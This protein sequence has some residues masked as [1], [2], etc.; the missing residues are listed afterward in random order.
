MRKILIPL[1]VL[2]AMVLA[3]CGTSQAASSCSKTFKVGFVTD[4]GKLGDK[5]FNDAGWKGVQDAAADSSLC[6]QA[7][8][9]E[10]KQPTDYTPNIQQFVDQKY[11]M[12]VAAGFLLGDDTLKAA[13]AN[14]NVKFTIVDSADFTDPTAPTNFT[15][16]LFKQDQ[17]AF[18]VGALAALMSKTNHVGGVYGLDVPA[19]V[20][21]RKG[22]ENGAKYINPSIKVDGVFQT[23][24]G[25]LLAAK[26]ANKPCIGV[27][28]DQYFTYPDVDPCLVTSS[29]KHISVAV[30]TI[31]TNAVKNQWPSGGVLTFDLKNDGVGLAPY[32]QWDSKVSADIKAKLLDITTKI[33]NGTLSTGA[34]GL[35]KYS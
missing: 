34:E 5:G 27:D 18:L 3:S 32:H 10:S 31:I 12:V 2:A 30:K 24:N 11:D 29:E 13:K 15:G 21:F 33:K 6:V 28:V 17:G 7:K 22:Y 35:T 20:Q 1:A 8:F 4:I 25:A 16:L 14:P 9:L 26:E 19:V 23:G